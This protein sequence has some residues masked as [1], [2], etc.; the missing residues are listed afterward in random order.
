MTQPS[1]HRPATGGEAPG[2]IAVLLSE[3]S[4][5]LASRHDSH[6]LD[7]EL[8]LAR[9]LGRPRS[10]LFTWPQQQVEP[11]QRRAFE[12]LVERRSQGEPIAYLLGRRAFWS[13]ELEI[14]AGALIPRPETELLIELALSLLPRDEPCRVLDL[15]TGSGAIALSLA[16]ERPAWSVTAV[17][18]S[19]A[20]VAVAQRNRDALGL[21]AVTLLQGHWYRPVSGCR[22]E[23]IVS[24]PPYVR[25]ADPHLTRGD[26]RHEPRSALDGG[27]DGLASLREVIAGAASHLTEGGL[28][29]LEH[30]ADQGPAVGELCARAG[31]I[32]V[33]THRDLAGLPRATSARHPSQ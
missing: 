12:T 20:A 8:L 3:A 4:R 26:V 5:R 19:D 11:A 18:F 28:L 10:Y 25:T 32:G 17:E 23:L 30:G 29:L 31:L 9:V 21:S 33:Q 27:P 6:R 7:A 14:D 13:L 22:Y 2:T 16:A 24:N 15:G 1:G